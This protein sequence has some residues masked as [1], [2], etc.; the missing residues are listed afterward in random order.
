MDGS[1][2]CWGYNGSGRLGDGIVTRWLTPTAVPGLG[3]VVEIAAG[4]VHTCAR[5]MDGTMRCWGSNRR[6]QIGPGSNFRGSTTPSP[7]IL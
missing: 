6:G 3:N 4:S 7:T 2:R 1:V 5:L